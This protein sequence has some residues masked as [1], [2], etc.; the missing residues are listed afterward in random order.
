MHPGRLPDGSVQLMVDRT[1]RPKGL[2]QVYFHRKFKLTYI[3]CGIV[4]YTGQVLEER[5]VNTH[6]MSKQQM[7]DRL[8]Q[9]DDFRYELT[10]LAT[11]AGVLCPNPAKSATLSGFTQ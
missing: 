5:R 6:G 1:D 10:A 7:V 3:H 2:R 8:S 9:F 11:Y 4:N